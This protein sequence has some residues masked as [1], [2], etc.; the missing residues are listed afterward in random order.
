MARE[1]DYDVDLYSEMVRTGRKPASK[2]SYALIEAPENGKGKGRERR[3]T[4]D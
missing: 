2:K 4:Q 3:R 1:A